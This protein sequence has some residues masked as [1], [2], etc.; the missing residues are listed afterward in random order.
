MM[1]GSPAPSRLRLRD[2]GR[3][4]RPNRPTRLRRHLRQ[5]NK[6][7]GSGA[8]LSRTLPLIQDLLRRSLRNSQ[9]SCCPGPNEPP[10]PSEIRR[11]E[12]YAEGK[13]QDGT[14]EGKG[15]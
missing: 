2:V 8:P 4:F 11:K 12:G 9:A 6:R 5:T 1:T 13:T 14:E 10:N 15:K 7:S 3:Q